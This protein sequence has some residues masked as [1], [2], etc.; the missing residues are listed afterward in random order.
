LI[1]ATSDF[2]AT[3]G[4]AAFAPIRMLLVTNGGDE[5]LLVR[6]AIAGRLRARGGALDAKAF[7]DSSHPRLSYSG[8]RPVRCGLQ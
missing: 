8:T 1:I 4:D 3:D 5:G 2:L 6:D 7:F